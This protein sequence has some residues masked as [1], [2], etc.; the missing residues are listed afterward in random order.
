MAALPEAA[1]EMREFLLST[2]SCWEIF[3]FTIQN[4]VNGRIVNINREQ[5]E[6]DLLAAAEVG[7][8]LVFLRSTEG[9]IPPACSHPSKKGPA[10]IA[11]H[12]GN[13]I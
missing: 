3:P 6:N 13:H 11:T 8:V 12:R 1:Q 9:I 10:R 7:G 2:V 5:G 4:H